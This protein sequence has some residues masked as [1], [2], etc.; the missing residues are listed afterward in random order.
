V[1]KDIGQV[2]NKLGVNDRPTT[3]RPETRS[4]TSR[5]ARGRRRAIAAGEEERPETATPG[6]Q[7]TAVGQRRSGGGDGGKPRVISEVYETTHNHIY[8]LH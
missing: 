7:K 5:G 8:M 3:S 1:D 2:E 4:K 6:R